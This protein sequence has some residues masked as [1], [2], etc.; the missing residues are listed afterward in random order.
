M[1]PYLQTLTVIGAIIAIPAAV[2]AALAL[3]RGA[4]YKAR[5]EET[6]QD[7]VRVRERLT[8]CE[9]SEEQ[10]KVKV[11]GLEDKN[12]ILQEMVTQRADVQH[13]HNLQEERFNEVMEVL[14]EILRE[15]RGSKS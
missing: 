12:V 5:L 15:I 7:N 3:M 10:L 9:H 14:G 8:S 4:Y 6:D 2:G 11:K 13:H 1:N